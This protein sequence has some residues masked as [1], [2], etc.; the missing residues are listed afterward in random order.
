MEGRITTPPTTSGVQKRA[1]PS[2][3]PMNHPA[4][5]NFSTWTFTN[6]RYDLAEGT[7][8]SLEGA[9]TSLGFVDNDKRQ[10]VAQ[11]LSEAD[12]LHTKLQAATQAWP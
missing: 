9:R 1:G 2:K 11:P 10:A 5:L 6:S 7:S 8:H 12:V 3:V 4:T